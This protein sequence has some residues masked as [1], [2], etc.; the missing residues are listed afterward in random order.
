MLSVLLLSYMAVLGAELIF[1]KS[2]I[3]VGALSTRV[4][5][6]ELWWGVGLALALKTGVAVLLASL[7]VKI[8]NDN[9]LRLMSAAVMFCLAAIY[10]VDLRAKK[11][12]TPSPPATGF[13]GT[14]QSFVAVF[15]SEW[16]DPGQMTVVALILKGSPWPVVWLGAALALGTKAAIGFTIGHHLRRFLPERAV[17]LVAALTLALLGVHTLIGDEGKP[18]RRAQGSR[19][20]SA[21]SAKN[22][23]FQVRPE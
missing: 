5:R 7:L 6:Q 1:D 20:T 13:A 21:L 2:L 8:Q 14:T 16:C 17:R 18:M 10:I 22:R 4:A 15:F 19:A 3:T 9:E 23:P 11:D 12:R